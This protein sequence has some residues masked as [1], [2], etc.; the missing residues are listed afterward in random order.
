MTI[1]YNDGDGHG[2]EPVTLV[3]SS[4]LTD[5]SGTLTAG[6]VAQQLAPANLS[7]TYLLIQNEHATEVM[8]INFTTTAVQ[9]QPSLQI[10]AL[11]TFVMETAAASTEVIS[12]IATTIGHPWSA[13][14]A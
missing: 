6:A 13:K 2:T 4:V 9:S 14:E 11:A 5:R 7:R 1:N 12:V 3:N 8:W 10:A